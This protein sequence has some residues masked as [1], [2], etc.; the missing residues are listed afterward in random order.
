MLRCIFLGRK[1]PD[2]GQPDYWRSLPDYWRVEGSINAP[3]VAG[4]R[5]T[6][7]PFDDR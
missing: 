4:M 6:K 2:P 7:P 3:G 1:N 5:I